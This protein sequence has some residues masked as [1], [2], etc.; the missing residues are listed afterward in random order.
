MRERLLLAAFVIALAAAIALG[1]V[2]V[3]Q[4]FADQR[5]DA[6]MVC[7]SAIQGRSLQLLSGEVLIA[8]SADGPEDR[9]RREAVARYRS[10][11]EA[12]FIS[13]VPPVCQELM[14]LPTFQAKVRAEVEEAKQKLD[15]LGV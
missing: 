7:N 9:E 6:V 11:Q 3:I 4:F 5:E 15:H 1:T 12:V 14:N 13:E 10:F 2:S 8:A